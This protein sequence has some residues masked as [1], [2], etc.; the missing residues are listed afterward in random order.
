MRREQE[1]LVRLFRYLA[2]IAGARG[3]DAIRAEAFGAPKPASTGKFD[4]DPGLFGVG[5]DV[6]IAAIGGIAVLG[7]QPSD[8]IDPFAGG[9]G[10]LHDDAG[11]V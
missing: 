3:A 11:E 8:Q 6:G 7:D 9:S 5:D 10:A 4:H 1:I 2:D